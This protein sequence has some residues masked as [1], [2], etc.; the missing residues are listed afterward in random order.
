MTKDDYKSS[1]E[2]IGLGKVIP[3]TTG[4]EYKRWYSY[5]SLFNRINQDI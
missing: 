2:A 3:K 4:M 5:F 1:L